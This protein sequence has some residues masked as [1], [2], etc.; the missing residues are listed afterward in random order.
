MKCNICSKMW[1]DCSNKNKGAEN[2]C[3]RSL[4]QITCQRMTAAHSRKPCSTSQISYIQKPLISDK[5]MEK[6]Q[7]KVATDAQTPERPKQRRMISS[8]FLKFIQTNLPLRFYSFI[9]CSFHG[10]KVFPLSICWIIFMIA[11]Q[12]LPHLYVQ[13]QNIFNREQCS[14]V[15]KN[16]IRC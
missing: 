11:Q 13:H 8:R 10:S 1:K 14:L 4:S 9:F 3:S 15:T 5:K 2:A 6:I 12:E 7:I 16:K